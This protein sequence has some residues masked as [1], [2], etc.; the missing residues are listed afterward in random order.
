[1]SERS[2]EFAPLSPL[3]TTPGGNMSKRQST[4]TCTQGESGTAGGSFSGRPSLLQR[5]KT[6]SEITAVKLTDVSLETAARD[7]RDRA[8]NLW[9]T[10]KPGINELY[11]LCWRFLE[12]HMMK[13]CL[14]LCFLC[15]YP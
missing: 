10:A 1:M 6:M 15:R 13:G 8:S 7:I 14:S 9:D 11:E 3:S 2:V 12:I 4:A 5:R